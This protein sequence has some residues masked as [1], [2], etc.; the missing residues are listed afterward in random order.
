MIYFLA[1]IPATMLTIAGYFVIYL[2]LRSEGTF[3]AFGRYLS[4]WAFTLAALVILAAIF[5]AAHGHYR[6]VGMMR[7]DTCWRW[8]G[9]PE[10]YGPPT[11]GPPGAAPPAA[12]PNPA[13][14]P[15]GGGTPPAGS[16]SPPSQ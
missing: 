12:L 14:P 7:G 8:H 1:L 9:G 4:F 16:A 15:A 11:I 13:A 6:G 2:S 5:A 10:F 3:R